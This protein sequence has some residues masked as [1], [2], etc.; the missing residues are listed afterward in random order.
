MAA[1]SY[2]AL[3][4]GGKKIKG[5]LEGDSERS[6]RSQLRA[7]KLRP[8]EVK[9]SSSRVAPGAKSDKKGLF[10]SFGGRKL[11]NRELSLLTRQLASLVQS[12]LPLDE[13][14]GSCAKQARKPNVKSLILQVR[15]RVLEGLSLAQAMAE[16]PKTFDTLYRAMI[17]AGEASGYLG[18]VLEQLAEYAERSQET[19][20]KLKGAMIYPIIMVLVS[21]AV[22]SFLMVKV[23]PELVSMFDKN[24]QELPGITTF[25]IATSDFLVNNGF[26]LL[27]LGVAVVILLPRFLGSKNVQPKWHRIQL[28][29]PLFGGFILQS[30]ASR[31]AS[32][33]GLLVNSGV[34]LVE[35]LK[36]ASQVLKNQDI[37][38]ASAEVAMSVQEGSSLHRALDQA[39][40]FPPLLV[41]MAASGEANGELAE[42]LLYAAKN[43]ERELTFALSSLMAILEPV[44]I[45]VMAGLVT[46]IMIGMLMPIFK[47]RDLV[48]V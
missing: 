29:I 26:I 1:F 3:D 41:Q 4:T 38:R 35:S 42:Q 14:L 25:L 23:V 43:E 18:P 8:L 5:V 39:E 6:I 48:G 31:Y 7:K 33:L 45:L 46:V 16:F 13:V 37:K 36:I 40:I 12:G 22:V 27:L 44:M 24:Q 47:M 19:S 10:A 11:K 32:T 21:I 9:S 30:E 20:Q 2:I 15:A 17:R 34:P 28:K